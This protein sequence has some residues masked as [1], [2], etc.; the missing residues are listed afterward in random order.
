[1]NR[2]RLRANYDIE[3]I[4]SR[5]ENGTMIVDV[6]MLSNGK[7]N[8]GLRHIKQKLYEEEVYPSEIGFDIMSFA[9]M[10]YMADTRIERAVHGQD[11]WTR[12]IELEIPVSNIELW[13]AQIP[14]IERMLKFLTGDF[15][16]IILS[17]RTWKFNNPQEVKEKS[18]KFDK[19]SL[20]SGGMDSLIST[21]NLMEDGKNTMLISHAGEGLTKNAQEKIR[22]S[23][24]HFRLGLI[25]CTQILYIHGWIYGWYSQI[26]IFLKAVMIIIQEADHFYL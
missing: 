7:L 1:M 17:S 2:Y 12:E 5:K 14:T 15:W 11:S 4:D 16:K 22:L 19:V 21:I 24:M 18:N 13:D 25:R 10:V 9:T 6:P 20:F 26:T 23:L 8:Y 3:N